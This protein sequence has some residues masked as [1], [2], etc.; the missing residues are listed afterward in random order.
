ML[1]FLLTISGVWWNTASVSTAC[2]CARAAKKANGV[3]GQLCR[4]VGNRDKD[5]GLYTTYVC[6][7]LEYAIQAWSPWAAGNKEVLEAVKGV[8][9]LKGRTSEDSLAEL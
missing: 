4:G 8:C 3:L 7:H 5:V 1:Y 9:N 6:P 2:A